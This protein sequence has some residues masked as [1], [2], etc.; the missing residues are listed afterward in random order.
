ML[1]DK[2]ET[3]NAVF[4]EWLESGVIEVPEEEERVNNYYLPHRPVFK[5][6]YATAVRSVFDASCKQK[7]FLSLHDC[8]TKG[9]NFFELIP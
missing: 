5:D 6:N 2:F 9:Q 3:Y 1:K 4:E 8:L 7:D